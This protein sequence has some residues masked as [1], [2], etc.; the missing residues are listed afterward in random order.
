TAPTS[1]AHLH[2]P[3]MPGESCGR[4][5]K[6]WE[7]AN[8][9]AWGT[10]TD[11]KTK[12]FLLALAL[13]FPAAAQ[14]QLPPGADPR[15]FKPLTERKDFLSWKLLAQ[16]DLVKMKDRYVPQFAQAIA[17]LDQKEVK[18]QGFMMPLQM[19]D[20]QPHFLLSAMPQTCAFSL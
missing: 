9:V 10:N 15:Q 17:A 11:M 8:T 20:K 1:R 19:G 18:V 13:A 2:R 6:A 5:A 3:D 14:H 7:S 12:A 16:V 4:I